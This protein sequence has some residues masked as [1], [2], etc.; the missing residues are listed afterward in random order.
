MRRRPCVVRVCR[1]GGGGSL[2]PPAPPSVNG[3]VAIRAAPPYPPW[4]VRRCCPPPSVGAALVGLP[5]FV[6]GRLLQHRLFLGVRRV[7]GLILILRRK[8]AA[9]R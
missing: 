1:G 2:R 3:R 7:G 8:C 4:G 5:P 6:V 9:R